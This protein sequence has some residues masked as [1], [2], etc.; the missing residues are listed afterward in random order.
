[1]EKVEGREGRG[2]E[3]RKRRRDKKK[4]AR[5]ENMRVGEVEGTG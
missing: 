3:K 1:M 2:G 5:D 4:I